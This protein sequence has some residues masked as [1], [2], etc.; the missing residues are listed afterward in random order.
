MDV[1]SPKTLEKLTRQMEE[2][3]D[4]TRLRVQAG[5]IYTT[6]PDKLELEHFLKDPRF[7]GIT[8]D[9]LKR[10]R[11]EDKWKKRRQNF[12]ERIRRDAENAMASKLVQ[13]QIEEQKR[14]L[15]VRDVVD[16]HILDEDLRPQAK[17]LE[18]LARAR[19]DV[20]RRVEELSHNILQE[21][22]PDD[23]SKAS[24][25]ALLGNVELSEDEKALIVKTLMAHRRKQIAATTDSV[26]DG[27]E[28][29]EETP[30]VPEEHPAPCEEDRP[31]GHGV[32]GLNDSDR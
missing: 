30:D 13:A 24:D 20:G 29:G 8:E 18:G 32:D 6:S 4:K 26:S 10:W 23:E 17:S 14:L 22:V 21:I 7:V 11:R 28:R 5:M 2:S 3:A 15:Q 12:F 9:D 1:T 19:I 16:L 31:S 25:D 27:E